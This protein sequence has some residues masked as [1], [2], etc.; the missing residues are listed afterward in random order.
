MIKNEK[1]KF[2]N[3]LL[4]LGSAAATIGI[5]NLWS[6]YLREDDIGLLIEFAVVTVVSLVFLYL[7]SGKKTFSLTGRK[8]LTT[9]RILLPTL[10]FPVFFMAAGALSSL[11]ERPAPNPDWLRDLL[12]FAASMFLVGI[13]EETVFRACAADVLCL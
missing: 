1:L 8:L 2:L 7:I 11:M 10:I 5:F 12:I 13:Y 4:W 9:V 3:I 6:R